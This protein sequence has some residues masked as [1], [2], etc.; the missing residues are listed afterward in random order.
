[1]WVWPQVGLGLPSFSTPPC[2]PGPLP[3]TSL[4]R[5]LP[6]RLK[7]SQGVGGEEG[8]RGWGG[9][10]HGLREGSSSCNGGM[11][12]TLQRAVGARP[13]SG[14]SRS[15]QCTTLKQLIA[16][17]SEVKGL[18]ACS[19]FLSLWLC[20]IARESR[21]SAVPRIAK[22]NTFLQPLTS[23]CRVF[24]IVLAQGCLRALFREQS[25][26][27]LKLVKNGFLLMS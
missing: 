21:R 13:T 14:G 12:G 9:K 27:P 3:H 23:S 1:M 10:G 11:G 25:P 16:R 22:E 24:S 6:E 20:S 2:A 17:N 8:G 4:G 26:P 18:K 7:K 19:Y 15:W 5:P